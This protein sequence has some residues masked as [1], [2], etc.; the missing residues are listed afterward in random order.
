M[1][2]LSAIKLSAQKIFFYSVCLLFFQFLYSQEEKLGISATYNFSRLDYK[3]GTQNWD[4]D[5]DKDGN[6][7]FANNSGLLKFDGTSWSQFKLLNDASAHCLKISNE[8]IIYVG[9]Y[10]KFGFFKADEKGKLIYHS[11][12]KALKKS[13]DMLFG[14]IWK[15]YLVGDE[16]IFQSF[17]YLF[18]LKNNE[19]KIIKA[20]VRFQ[21]SYQI[22]NSL[23]I[24]DV[25]KGIY[26]YTSGKLKLLPNTD[27]LNKTEVWGVLPF[28]KDKLLIAT[29]DKGLF[30]Y[31][32]STLT[33]FDSPANDF[34]LKNS[35]LG[36][37]AIAKD[38]F[39]LNTI[40]NGVIVCNEKGIITEHFNRETGL[41]NNTVLISFV[42]KSG[43]IWL[44][45]DNGISLINRTSP[46]S[47]LA[48]NHN[49]T[50]TYSSV[51]HQ[52]KLYVATNQGVFWSQW[53]NLQQIKPFQLVNGTAGQAWNLQ[54]VDGQ[55]FCS[56]NRGL[57]LITNEKVS[58]VLTK[59]GWHAIKRLPNS[60][61]K[62]ISSSYTGFSIF[63]KENGKL[64]FS[65]KVKNLNLDVSDFVID[66]NTIWFENYGIVN[67]AILSNDLSEISSTK[68]HKNILPEKDG[69]WKIIKIQK[70]IYFYNSNQFFTFDKLDQKFVL[71][72][73]FTSLF[74]S[75]PK[76]GN[77]KEDK[78]GNLWYSHGESLGVL[79]RNG[80]KYTNNLKTMSFLSGN[81]ISDY[82]TVNII[83]LEH[84]LIGTNEGL[85]IYNFK[86]ANQTHTPPRAF[87]SSL[88]SPSDTIYTERI[89]D[90]STNYSLPYN[91]NKVMFTFSSN[92]FANPKRL[93]F[94]YQ[95]DGLENNWSKWNNLPF[96]EYSALKEGNYQMKVKARNSY[97]VVSKIDYFDFQIL[98]PWYRSIYAYLIYVILIFSAVYYWQFRIKKR[99][100]EKQYYSS[101]EQNRVY[102]EKET[103]MKQGQLELEKEIEQLKNEKLTIELLSKDKELVSNSL[104]INRK[105]NKL[106]RISSI[107]KDLNT[108]LVDSP[109]H[110]ILTNL[111]KSILKEIKDDDKQWKELENHI[112]NIHMDFLKRLREKHPNITSRELILCTYL[113]MNMSSKEIAE[114][115]SI[116][117]EGVELARYRLR[118]KLGVDKKENLVGYLLSI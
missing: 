57:M 32:N 18:V 40:L 101:I 27:S 92:D 25:S 17:K 110:T 53:T 66:G 74:K 44:G 1:H 34:V 54:I 15:I 82:F 37:I 38:K 50:T 117:S 39:L 73:Y 107:L 45:L 75:L 97:G 87:I 11:L 91:S 115:V 83:D 99:L 16:V 21:F 118:K 67:Q 93:E 2:C 78:Y 102:L 24:Q 55:L 95:L 62:F 114:L 63:N 28:Q 52:G 46:I 112:Q 113:L 105:N 79:I 76:I 30:I 47:L 89:N 68:K 8:G 3:A 108:K 33:P 104:I 4:I 84:I 35:C 51:L 42:D 9:A 26:T 13:D 5:E 96:K 56:H 70:T 111:N 90:K 20:P 72:N 106:K 65:N 10:N 100:E 81:L 61:Q 19:I 88:C 12:S 59:E 98:P 48:A 77:I 49:L 103:L 7:Y 36:V 86:T 41:H 94:S 116:S 31:E 58:E 71:D 29:M 69:F 6:K 22:N 43:N 109:F 64:S 80:K 14:D 23:Y 60:Q 85:L